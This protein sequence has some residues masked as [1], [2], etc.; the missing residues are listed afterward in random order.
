MERITDLHNDLT[1]II[2]VIVVIV[3]GLLFV[4]VREVQDKAKGLPR[5]AFTH[6]TLLEII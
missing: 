4:E 5:I 2:V 1:G 6:Q 3:S